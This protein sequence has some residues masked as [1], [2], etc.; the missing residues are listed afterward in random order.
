MCKI[1]LQVDNTYSGTHRGTKV[2]TMHI[3]MDMV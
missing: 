2:A 3:D 1:Q